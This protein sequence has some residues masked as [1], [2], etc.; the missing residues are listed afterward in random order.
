MT[1]Q[2]ALFENAGR[3]HFTGPHSA[4]DGEAGGTQQVESESHGDVPTI[5]KQIQAGVNFAIV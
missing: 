3:R 1:R 4:H 5:M 2:A